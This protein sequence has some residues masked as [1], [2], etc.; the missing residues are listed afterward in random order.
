MHEWVFLSVHPLHTRHWAKPSTIYL[1]RWAVY[2]F[3]GSYRRCN[4]NLHESQCQRDS[5]HLSTLAV[6]QRLPGT[7]C[8]EGFWSLPTSL[9][10]VMLH[11]NPPQVIVISEPC[12]LVEDGCEDYSMESLPFWWSYSGLRHWGLPEGKEMAALAVTHSKSGASSEWQLMV[13]W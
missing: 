7:V 1:N 8:W 10:W 3:L 13:I 6:W 2:H 12:F 4:S 5:S 9:L 11:I